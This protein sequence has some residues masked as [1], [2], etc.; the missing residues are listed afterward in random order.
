[1]WYCWRLRMF[2]MRETQM[3]L[4]W[5]YPQDK[6]QSILMDKLKQAHRSLLSHTNNILKLLNLDHPLKLNSN[7]ELS[8]QSLEH[9]HHNNCSCPM[10]H[11]E[12]SFQNKLY[13]FDHRHTGCF[14]RHNKKHPIHLSNVLGTI[15]HFHLWSLLLFWTWTRSN[16]YRLQDLSNGCLS[17]FVQMLFLDIILIH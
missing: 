1:M 7:K 9:K 6:F 13:L 14:F 3:L 2:E 8:H 5:E 10:S 16:L 17:I 11:L 15:P 12:A 4:Y